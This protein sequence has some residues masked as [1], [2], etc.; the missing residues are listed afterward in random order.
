[1]TAIAGKL[2]GRT[3]SA[4][5][6]TVFPTEADSGTVQEHIRHKSHIFFQDISGA[7][8]QEGEFT[9]HL[10]AAVG[11]SVEDGIPVALIGDEIAGGEIQLTDAMKALSKTV[12]M[13]AVDF[14][15]TRYDLG[16]KLGFLKANVDLALTHPEVSEDFRKYIKE[17]AERL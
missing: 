15:G 13:T 6:Q 14:E 17:L 8:F 3:F 7:G 12:G 4:D 5:D 2:F 1:M 11:R 16:S 9:F 10:P